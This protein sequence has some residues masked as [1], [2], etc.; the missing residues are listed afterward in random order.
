MIVIKDTIV[1]EELLERC[2]VCDLGA[3]KGEC[4]IDGDAGAPIEKEE[5][6]ELLKCIDEVKSFMRPEGIESLEANGLYTIEEKNEDFTLY[7]NAYKDD[8][9]EWVTPLI[10]G[11]ECAFVI[12]EQGIAKCAIEKAFLEKGTNFMKPISCHLY[13][14]RIVKYK[15]YRAVNYHQW[16]ICRG[17]LKKGEKSG[18]RVFK[19]LKEP[20]IRM[21]GKEWYKELEDAYNYLKFK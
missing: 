5:I 16:H 20:L 6:S 3:C 7:L 4:C 21:F 11:K 1:S 2:F 8:D 17:A 18:V 13:P 15:D 9:G 19:F 10:D 14:V 12:F